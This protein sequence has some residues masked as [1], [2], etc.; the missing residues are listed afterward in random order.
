[1]YYTDNAQ[2]VLYRSGTVNVTADQVKWGANG[3]RLPTEAE[4]EKAARGGS[5]GQRFPW[6]N[7]IAHAQANYYSDVFYRYDEGPTRGFQPTFA[8]GLRPFTAPAESFSANGFG[9]F[10][11]AGN[12]REWCWDWIGPYSGNSDPRG[13]FQASDRVARGG[14]WI[15]YAFQCRSA[16]RGFHAP[17]SRQFDLGFRMARSAGR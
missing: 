12:V 2:T 11:L 8:T 4:W 10:G 17:L 7:T 3:Y 14:S 13:G 9:L 5:A 15:S 16:Y 6:G 1:V